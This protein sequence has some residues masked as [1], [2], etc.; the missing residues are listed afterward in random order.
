MR[1]KMMRHLVKMFIRID[2]GKDRYNNSLNLI[3]LK[4]IF[5]A[6]RPWWVSA[7]DTCT[8]GDD[9]NVPELHP[10]YS[11]NPLRG[12]EDKHHDIL[13]DFTTII[14]E[15]LGYVNADDEWNNEPD[16]DTADAQ[17]LENAY[18]SNQ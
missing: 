12:F 5:G 2:L 10:D 18:G 7:Y 13:N 16:D 17:W 11:Q 9:F 8:N 6:L 15:E 14:A 3:L 4:S 1:K